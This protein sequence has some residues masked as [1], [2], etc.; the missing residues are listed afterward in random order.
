GRDIEHRTV[1]GD[2]IGHA[3][4]HRPAERSC[5]RAR[6]TQE[7]AISSRNLLADTQPP[8]PLCGGLQRQQDAEPRRGDQRNSAPHKSASERSFPPGHRID[9]TTRGEPAVPRVV[10]ACEEVLYDDDALEK[11]RRAMTHHGSLLKTN[12]SPFAR[13]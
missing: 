9:P 1:M 7:R 12:A 13:V 2:P 4:F 3:L 5:Y 11:D 10:G 6:R 8:S